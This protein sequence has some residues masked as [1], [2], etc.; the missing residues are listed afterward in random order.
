MTSPQKE[1]AGHAPEKRY[2]S[3]CMERIDRI[4]KHPVY[5]EHFQKL[6][7]AERTRVFCRHTLSHFLD[8]A[9]IAH[10]INLEEQLCIAKD[11]IYAAALLHDIGR[12]RQISDGTPHDIAGAQL[13]GQIMAECGFTQD[14]TDCVKAAI[15]RHRD[16]LP[17][18]KEA[19]CLSESLRE[20]AKLLPELLRRADKL[21]RCCFDCPAQS[22]CNWTEEKRNHRILI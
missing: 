7:E 16:S 20:A 12:Y 22:E 9:R 6:Q 17:L 15:A 11:I 21:S 5:Q 8:T 10:I 13:C 2:T 1:P 14:E 3:D 18:H 4:W 19:A